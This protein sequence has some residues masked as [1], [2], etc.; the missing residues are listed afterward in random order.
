MCLKWITS[1]GGIFKK[2]YK[3]FTVWEYKCLNGLII[4]RES[5]GWCFKWILKFYSIIFD[6]KGDNL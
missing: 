4:L 6:R 1:W 3:R 5:G 2:E